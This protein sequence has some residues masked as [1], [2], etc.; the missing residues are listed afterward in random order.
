MAEEEVTADPSDTGGVRLLRSIDIEL[1]AVSRDL[2]V[3]SELGGVRLLRPRMDRARKR[4]PQE[5]AT[6]SRD[7]VPR[8]QA[9]EYPSLILAA[10]RIGP[11]CESVIVSW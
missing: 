9:A 8:H 4:V 10:L 2:C 6:G 7:V 11:L 1:N 3:L 5:S